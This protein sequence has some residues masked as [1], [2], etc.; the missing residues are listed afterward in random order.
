MLKQ[1][2]FYS[3]LESLLG[4]DLFNRAFFGA[5]YATAYRE[6][7]G[8]E[9][10]DTCSS[11]PSPQVPDDLVE[12]KSHPELQWNSAPGPFYS[13]EEQLDAI[14]R[15]YENS[16]KPIRL[17]LDR[18]SERDQFIELVDRLRN[19]GWKDWHILMA[20]ANLV[21]NYRVNASVSPSSP[22][23]AQDVTL[24]YMNREED[25]K[26][27][28]IPLDLVTEDNLRSRMEA[29]MLASLRGLGHE[30]NTATPPFEAVGEFLGQR[31][32]Y[33]DLDAE[34]DDPFK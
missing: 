8:R 16:V 18:L 30:I 14:R 27:I 28:P 21:I 22:N 2:D 23:S 5:R 9:E 3:E 11:Q 19:E 24:E 32:N 20:L 6:F 13:E 12:P 33:W 4:D 26:S 17:T 1:E 29:G 25:E 31:Y 7:M 34:H 10:F 15:R